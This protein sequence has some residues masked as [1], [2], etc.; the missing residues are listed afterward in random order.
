MIA[1]ANCNRLSFYAYFAAD[2]RTPIEETVR[3]MNFLI[4]RG[5]AFYWVR[6]HVNCITIIP[7]HCGCFIEWALPFNGA[8]VLTPVGGGGGGGGA[9]NL[10]VECADAAGGQDLRTRARPGPAVLRPKPL[11]HADARPVRA[12]K[13]AAHLHPPAMRTPLPGTGDRDAI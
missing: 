7:N 6:T 3:G 2:P 9:G 12:A 8:I 11:Q 4:D 10:R 1:V 5:M 13:P